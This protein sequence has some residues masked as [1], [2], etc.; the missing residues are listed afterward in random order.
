MEKISPVAYGSFAFLPF[1][2]SI[3]LALFWPMIDENISDQ[4]PKFQKTACKHIG[5][6]FLKKYRYVFQVAKEV[7]VCHI[8]AHTVDTVPL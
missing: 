3:K 6:S 7:P 4:L 2:P 8:P 1:F 5:M